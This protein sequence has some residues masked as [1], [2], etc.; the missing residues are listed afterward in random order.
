MQKEYKNK[1]FYVKKH[2]CYDDFK[3]KRNEERY[4]ICERH[5]NDSEV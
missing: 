3:T 4:K 2:I 1:V 5:G